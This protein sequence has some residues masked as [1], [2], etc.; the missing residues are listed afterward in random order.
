MSIVAGLVAGLDSVAR[1]A[2][3]FAGVGFLIGGLDDLAIDL[4][5][6]VRRGWRR[7]GDADHRLAA[8][9]AA[10]GRVAIFVPAWDEASVIDAMLATALD[11]LDHPDYR[12]YVG[13]YPNDRATIDAVAAVAERDARVRLVIGSRP[14]P[15]TKA[16]CLNS[17]WRALVADAAERPIKAVV[18]HDADVVGQGTGKAVGVGLNGIA[19][20]RS[21]R[22]SRKTAARRSTQGHFG[23]AG[24]SDGGVPSSGAGVAAIAGRIR[25]VSRFPVRPRSR[26]ADQRDLHAACKRPTSV[27]RRA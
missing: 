25:R 27:M 14:G 20:D 9:D 10:T 18:L 24:Q 8:P 11:R 1:E 15:T 13:T 16:D 19:W 22:M 3:L 26:F 12:L 4:V 6:F 21:S 5:Y 7:S 23:V 17:L 2:M